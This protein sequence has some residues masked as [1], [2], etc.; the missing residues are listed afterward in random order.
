MAVRPS[1]KR[2]KIDMTSLKIYLRGEKKTGKSTLFRDLILEKYGNAENGLLIGFGAEVGY[3]LLDNLNSVQIE[4]YADFKELLTWLITQKGKE[5]DIRMV[6]LDTIDELLPILEKEVC[7]L[8]TIETKK[9]CKSLNS[10]FGGFGSGQDKLK[11]LLKEAVI[12]LSKAGITPFAISHTKVKTIKEKGMNEDEG[13]NVLTGNIQANYDS[14]LAEIFDV[15]CVL[16]IDKD[17][18]DGKVQSA[19]RKLHLRGDY[20]IDAGS[21]FA[22]GAVPDYIIF[23]GDDTAKLFIDTLEEGMR[24]S[25]KTPISN[26]ELAKR[27]ADELANRE[28]MAQDFI[29]NVASVDVE[30]NAKYIDEIKVLF[31]GAIDTKKNKVRELMTSNGI[32]KFDVETNKTSVLAEILAVLKA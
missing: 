17:V 19:V 27:K 16:R 2:T 22:N 3:E 32:A 5:H 20:Y 31:A 30:L 14:L 11:Q 23:E 18:K 7:R 26:E 24:K 25:L 4:N 1:V 28:A 12:T 13:Y 8:S 6:A 15:C 10:A 21:R 29:E 9:P